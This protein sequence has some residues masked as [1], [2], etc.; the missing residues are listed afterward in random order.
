[1]FSPIGGSQQENDFFYSFTS[2]SKKTFSIFLKHDIQT[3]LWHESTRIEASLQRKW[4]N[5]NEG[6]KE[7]L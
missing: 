1:M 7:I 5:G 2:P 6:N 4:H 3:K